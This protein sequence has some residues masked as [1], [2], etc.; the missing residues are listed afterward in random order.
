MRIHAGPVTVAVDGS[1]NITLAEDTGATT[2]RFTPYSI[3]SITNGVINIDFDYVISANESLPFALD[4]AELVAL[5]KLTALPDE[6]SDLVGVDASGNLNLLA[7]FEVDVALGL[8]LLSN[9]KA[10]FLDVDETKV[11]ASGSASV[12]DVD[13]NANIGPFVMSVLGGEADIDLS[14]EI[15][16]LDGGADTSDG[17]MIIGGIPRNEVQELVIDA[18]IGQFQLKVTDSD[19]PS[20]TDTTVSLNFDATKADIQTALGNLT[21]FAE[22][23]FVV[24]GADGQFEI[25]FTSGLG[26]QDITL[27]V[28]GNS[29]VVATPKVEGRGFT[30]DLD[31]IDSFFGLGTDG[32]AI[33][34][35]FGVRGMATATL[36][37]FFSLGGSDPQP[38][39]D[40]NEIEAT[41]NLLQWFDETDNNSGI[42]FTLPSFDFPSLEIPG[43]FA[44][45]SDPSVVV[46]G[47][48]SVFKQVQNTLN[49]ELFG[50]ELPFIGA[51]LADNPLANFVED[52]RLDFLQPLAR[53]M[54]E[55]NV[56]LGGLEDLFAGVIDD[57]FG[58]EGLDILN[59]PLYDT[60]FQGMT[61]LNGSL[62]SEDPLMRER[63]SA[64]DLNAATALQLEFDIGGSI[65][66]DLGM[67]DLD[68]GIPA[69]G[70]D[71][72]ANPVITLVW[73]LHVGFGV[74]IERGFYFV[75]NYDADGDGTPD[76]E[77]SVSLNMDLGT[78]EN[79]A[80]LEGNLGF[81]K[82]EITDGVDLNQDGVLSSSAKNPSL[83]DEFSKL[84]VVASVDIVDS[85]GATDTQ[86]AEIG[87][88][89][90][91]LSELISQPIRETLVFDVTG[92]AILRAHGLVNLGGLDSASSGFSLSNALPAI[93][94]DVV[95]DFE[96]G[97]NSKTGLDIG[98]PE[99]AL[100]NI[101][102]DL[103]DFISGFAGDILST[104]KEVLD[105]LDWLIAPEDGLLN[106]RLPLI[107]DLLGEAVRIRDLI[108]L[109]DPVNGPKVEA[110]LDFV[111]G[112]Y[113]L[114][115]LVEGAAKEA[116]D[117]LYLNFGDLI[118]FD[119]DDPNKTGDT[120]AEKYPLL[121]DD[122][123]TLPSL[124]TGQDLRDLKDFSTITAPPKIELPKTTKP[125]GSKTKSFTSGVSK[126]GSIYFPIL[127]ADTVMNLLLG[128]T[129][130]LVEVELP[131]FS[132]EFL[133]R[134]AIPIVG[135]LVGTF[136]GGFGGTFDLGFGYDTLGLQQ[137]LATDNEAFLLNG[138]FINDVDPETGLDRPEITF[139][140]QIGV[141]AG[142]SIGP[143]SFGVEGGIAAEVLFNFADL[144]ND[145]KIRFWEL[146]ANTLANDY[147]PLA[148]FDIS[149]V[150]EFFLLAYIEIDLFLFSFSAEF[151]FARI[152][153]FSFDIDFERPGILAS[154]QGDTLTLNIGENAAARLNGDTRDIDETIFVKSDTNGNVTVWSD[155]FGISEVVA[156]L[157]PFTGVTKIVAYAGEGNDTIDLSGVAADSGITAEI[158]GGRGNDT[159]VGTRNDDELFGDA[160]NDKIFGHDGA[161]RLE[162][163]LGDDTLA[164]GLGRDELLGNEGDDILYGAATFGTPN[165]TVVIISTDEHVDRLDGGVGDDTNYLGTNDILAGATFG[166]SDFV[167]ASADSVLD[168]SLLLDESVLSEADGLKIFIQGDKVFG[169]FGEQLETTE[170]ILNS[171][172][173]FTDLAGVQALNWFEHQIGITSG[174]NTTIIGTGTP[175]TFYVTG[176]PN[177][178]T[179]N[180]L[181]PN[182][183]TLDGGADADTFIFFNDTAN[184]INATVADVGEGFQDENTIRV[185]GTS[186]AGTFVDESAASDG[187]YT[188][189]FGRITANGEDQITVT[190]TAITL[191]NGTITYAAPVV[192][193]LTL[194]PRQ[195]KTASFSLSGG[196]TTTGVTTTV[197]S[198]NTS[199]E[200]A[201]ETVRS[202]IEGLTDVTRVTRDGLSF[203]IAYSDPSNGVVLTPITVVSGGDA[204]VT[205]LATDQLK[206]EISTKADVDTIAVE[207]TAESAPVRVDGGTGDDTITVG[208]SNDSVKGV[209][210][211]KGFFKPGANDGFGLGPLVLVGNA[212]HDTVIFDDSA[213]SDVEAGNLTAFLEKRPL[214][215]APVEVGVLSGLGM[216]LSVPDGPALDGRVEF[217]GFET[218][219]VRMGTGVNDFTVGGGEIIN[220]L[221]LVRRING[222]IA[223]SVTVATERAGD[224]ADNEIQTVEVVAESGTFTLSL[225]DLGVTETAPL[226]HDVDAVTLKAALENLTAITSVNVSRTATLLISNLSGAFAAGEIITD[227]AGNQAT[228]QAVSDDRLE[229][230]MTGA[231][232]AV[233]DVITGSISGA[234]TTLDSEIPGKYTIEFTDPGM[235]DVDL[236]RFDR[237]QL[238]PNNFVHTISG[239][240][241][242]DG[243]GGAD[244]I[245]VIAT[246]QLASTLEI[247]D[248]P[249]T[250][251]Y[252]AS[253][254]IPVATTQDGV[255]NESP[256]TVTLDFLSTV[257]AYT[258][259]F[260]DVDGTETVLGAEASAV[261]PFYDGTNGAAYAETLKRAIEDLRLV[262]PGFVDVTYV[263]G[264]GFTVTF[265]NK[266]G[267]LPDLFAIETSLLIKGGA[268]ADTINI[269]SID[270]ATYVLG[271]GGAD[272]I[273]VNVDLDGSGVVINDIPG[274]SPAQATANGVND[275]LT[276]DGEADGDDYFVYLFGGEANSLVNL[277]DSGKTGIDNA[278]IL[279]TDDPDLFLLRAAVAND[280]LAFVAM[281]KPFEAVDEGNPLDIE[282][283]NYDSGI[284]KLEV[285]ALDGDDHVAVDDT[286]ADI[287]IYGGAGDDYF[288]VGQLYKAPRTNSADIPN[289]DVFA[290][291]ETTR[292]FL[293][294]GNSSP[295]SISGGLGNDEFVV[296]H[297]LAPL[298]LFGNAGDDNFLVRAFA[299]A[300]S[301]EDLRERTDISG[302]AGA[303]LIQYAVNAPVFIDGGDGFDTL[304]VIGTEFGD[305]F[306]VTENSIYGA[307]LNITFVR[308][309]SVEVDGAEGDDRFFIRGTGANLVT[310]VTGGL[311]SDTFNVNGP[312]P[313]VISNDLLGHSGLISHLV[314]SNSG[315]SEYAGLKV[316]GI[317][318]NVADDDEPAIRIIESDG[319]SVVSQGLGDTDN[320]FVVL[321]RRPENG[322]TVLVKAIAPRGV[323]FLRANGEEVIDPDGVELFFTATNWNIPQE[324]VFEADQL[325]T[326]EIKT[327][328]QGDVER[329]EQQVLTINATGGTFALTDS[330]AR[331]TGDITYD[332]DDR[333]TIAVRIQA[334]LD[335]L[336]GPNVVTVGPEVQGTAKNAGTNAGSFTILDDAGADFLNRAVRSGQDIVK[337]AEVNGQLVI[338]AEATI[339]EVQEGRLRTTALSNG[340]IW[341]TTDRYAILNPVYEGTTSFTINFNTAGD[342]TQLSTEYSIPDTTDP[343]NQNKTILVRPELTANDIIG[344]APGFITHDV[345][346]QDGSLGVGDSIVGLFVDGDVAEGSRFLNVLGLPG[347]ITTQGD[348]AL[349]GAT[350]KII[351]GAGIGESRLIVGNDSLTGE[352]EVANPWRTALDD[353][354]RIEILRYDGVALPSIEVQIVGDDGPGL[355]V[356][357]TD[358][359]TYAVEAEE[360]HGFIDT[361]V[362]GTDDDSTIGLADKVTVAL[363]SGP[364]GNVTV[365]LDGAG[366]LRFITGNST[367]GYKEVTSLTF[368]SSNWSAAQDVYIIGTD[369]LDEEGLHKAVFTLSTLF[370]SGTA[371]E[372]NNNST[373]LLDSSFV[374]NGSVDIGDVIQ[375]VTDGSSATITGVSDGKLT[376]T[377]LTGGTDDTWD[378]GDAY[379]VKY[380]AVKYA[381]E[382]QITVD[383]YDNEVPGVLV[384][385]SS[386]STD[387]IET[388][389]SRGTGSVALGGMTGY[390]N[391]SLDNAGERDRYAVYLE[392]GQTYAFSLRGSVTGD[393]TLGDPYLRIY[394]DTASSLYDPDAPTPEIDL[395]GQN[396]DGGIGLNSLLTYI[397]PANES[398]V[399]YLEAGAYADWYAGTYTLSASQGQFTG[400]LDVSEDQAFGK[401]PRQE[402]QL[403]LDETKTYT[404]DLKGS[405]SDDGTLRDPYL[406]IFDVDGNLTSNDVV[407]FRTYNDDG[408][409][410]YNSHLSFSPTSSGVYTIEAG[411]YADRGKGGTYTLTWTDIVDPTHPVN[412]GHPETPTESPLQ[413]ANFQELTINANGGTFTLTY[414]G[415]TTGQ[416][417]YDATATGSGGQIDGVWQSVEEALESLG[418][419]NPADVAVA[420]SGNVYSLVF[421]DVTT[422]LTVDD[423]AL[424]Q[425]PANTV[426]G[427]DGLV[428]NVATDDYQIVLTSAPATGETVTVNLVADPTRAQR[429]AG[430]FGIRSFTDQVVV[431]DAND[432]DTPLTFDSS[433]WFTPQTVN[434]QAK[435]DDFV[436]G[437]DSKS[438]ATKL[439]QANSIEGPLVIT[440]GVSD[441]R[442]ADL[443]R[444]PIMLLGE[445]NLKLSIGTVSDSTDFTIDINLAEEEAGV[446][447]VATTTEGGSAGTGRVVTTTVGSVGEQDG[448]AIYA[449]QVLTIDAVSGTF[450][451]ALTNPNTGEVKATNSITFDPS[452]TS[453]DTRDAIE[454]GLNG[455]FS[456]GTNDVKVKVE[457]SGSTYTITFTEPEGEPVEDLQ[458]IAGSDLTRDSINEIQT[459]TIDASSGTFNLDAPGGKDENQLVP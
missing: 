147:N 16:L 6:F 226:A 434:V 320:Y 412:E 267:D 405:R 118:L 228:L 385:Q 159:I 207:S 138:F 182:G 201:L 442:S 257:G 75:S 88:G 89:R 106:L 355:D 45:L 9:D 22:K 433:N 419:L 317:S 358:A 80:V 244:V 278:D 120:F 332:P 450:K 432:G 108:S 346:V 98:S 425:G 102:L 314:E 152:E 31:E 289:A 72:T 351:A 54:V 20:N 375:N 404:F 105:P 283:V 157:A 77:L 402:I 36:P 312:T 297:N 443:E 338:V 156:S 48:D 335:A 83:S 177:G 193:F 123:L 194:T 373:E 390:V 340:E 197:T 409:K 114:I 165:Y 5:A 127:E 366:Q 21:V 179:P 174:D 222:E 199:D 247:D 396:D 248:G 330:S 270:S 386:G 168:F 436:D 454:T 285:F 360:I 342:K 236:L 288:Q 176:T 119:S 439:D 377:A 384:L 446:A 311:G 249:T 196:V 275:L 359:G 53:T 262:G 440:G 206:I 387:V 295:L 85:K 51:A 403:Y 133:Y 307:G 430:E 216:T 39:G 146:A 116:G 337:L 291:I 290:T 339:V 113:F 68:L 171:T 418:G 134:Q 420:K 284:D 303:D 76:P 214:I 3:L 277:F 160:G 66:I 327:V 109:Y 34:E 225:G 126:K 2:A 400:A 23:D 137:Y 57:V 47:L 258:L 61:K 241:L 398:G 392:A 15:A 336:L 363:A 287:T 378:T 447:S 319:S 231:N 374:D 444:E 380:A 64:G 96:I 456:T 305:D 261:L 104:V 37:L 348:D 125:Q 281:L 438:F 266:L 296:Y 445:T 304:I 395:V 143:A 11:T 44:L 239:M 365:A 161:D 187:D 459:I 24:T 329:K 302:G 142:V 59:T 357:Q 428:E 230:E 301:Q 393:G 140:A 318:A 299:L 188:L 203:R 259:Q 150:V 234:T 250:L 349:R 86:G 237:S 169:G 208:G 200:S 148:V 397:V 224:T 308:V 67:L 155:Q 49:G 252:L 328:R 368:T 274:V 55:N 25:E 112:L 388:G 220:E 56:S 172:F 131:E 422:L 341:N 427:E 350:V 32:L 111:E 453:T 198:F 209:D 180:G 372:S 235:Q 149:G 255:K 333:V 423:A 411:A 313:D 38:L 309:E 424:S 407:D 413:D 323:R 12:S 256:E 219:D 448:E 46:K 416:I 70:L 431:T 352:I 361:N 254:R 167:D 19:N 158:H 63:I 17:R 408:G 184:S 170:N 265:N 13:F 93:E 458:F 78:A 316:E 406:R 367:D 379:A 331:T 35:G 95:V 7:D 223:G 376:T 27:N 415:E 394:D 189:G 42:N 211:I 369:D 260:E 233:N 43:L 246:N 166:S 144:D 28:V 276:I 107:S 449:T 421:T 100:A 426:T 30:T 103:G 52:F 263:S 294:N 94:L 452:L 145:T 74:D 205:D 79:P 215:A 33:G 324:I 163:G 326:A 292:G 162:G 191:G 401:V 429:G 29:D 417:K 286:R 268:G 322:A 381:A 455:L 212:G 213:D 10:F 92:G 82:L 298:Q 175:D 135:P 186:S 122:P 451:L 99:V 457:G 87:D 353:S 8:D 71:I 272:E 136:S 273:N 218:V 435:A 130:T 190:N 242:I 227:V 243:G 371:T 60:F 1:G 293:S 232:F 383:V 389:D 115:D 315:D 344:V 178:L 110:F 347:F 321:T 410:G 269:E 81:L 306:V 164:G 271:G 441:D 343:N 217:E 58:A 354:S 91:T 414:A 84:F 129:A 90:L 210:G 62:L 437:G 69:L 40:P 279:G 73:S 356:R 325:G 141:G 310:K 173:S 334:E 65:E 245:S 195:D 117:G 382:E 391:G 132:F 362:A 280:G 101:Q 229:V 251:D 41:F 181:T 264:N 4:L 253:Q 364:T 183:L 240:T 370:A 204:K 221:P 151:E 124:P 399:Y 345:S 50:V 139:N 14:I 121:F 300:G 128:K 185:L 202:Q 153:L 18:T 192:Q 282:R 154:Q 238:V 97:Y 26:S